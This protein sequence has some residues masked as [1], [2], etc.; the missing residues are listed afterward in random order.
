VGPTLR[1]NN[2]FGS[3]YFVLHGKIRPPVTYKIDAFIV[4]S[5][6]AGK[7]RPEITFKTSRQLDM[8]I[9]ANCAV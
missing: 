8:Q 3:L 5:I 2:S 6:V 7:T 1:K 9:E 4:P